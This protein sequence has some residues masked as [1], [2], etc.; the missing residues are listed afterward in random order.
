MPELVSA[1]SRGLVKSVESGAIKCLVAP[2]LVPGSERSARGAYVKPPHSKL[3]SG[4]VW[5]LRKV[6]GSAADQVKRKGKGSAHRGPDVRKRMP[7][8]D[9]DG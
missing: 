5:L 8:E 9:A 3:F 4:S 1:A 2:V 6:F 7:V